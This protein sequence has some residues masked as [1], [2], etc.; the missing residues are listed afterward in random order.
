M[1]S[2]FYPADG[3]F[4]DPLPDWVVG[5]LSEITFTPW[6]QDPAVIAQCFHSP[7]AWVTTM[8]LARE[9]TFL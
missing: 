1:S 2:S 3:A 8:R 5:G 7:S 4:N 9:D 6:Q